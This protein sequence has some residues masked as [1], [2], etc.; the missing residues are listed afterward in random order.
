M[1]KSRQTSISFFEDKTEQVT[2]TKFE[3][4]LIKTVGCFLDGHSNFNSILVSFKVKSL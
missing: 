1:T 4:E 2:K 3:L